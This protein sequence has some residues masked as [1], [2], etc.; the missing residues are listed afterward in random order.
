MGMSYDY[1]PNYFPC[2]NKW[3]NKHYANLFFSGQGCCNT[4]KFNEQNKQNVKKCK[5][6]IN[7]KLYEN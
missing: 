1:R 7:C 5:E 3:F 4:C 2:F 6:C